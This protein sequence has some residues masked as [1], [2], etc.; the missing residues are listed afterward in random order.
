MDGYDRSHGRSL[1]LCSE[2]GGEG[3]EERIDGTVRHLLVR[4]RSNRCLYGDL[5]SAAW[6][7]SGKTYQQATDIAVLLA[8]GKRVLLYRHSPA[9]GKVMKKLVGEVLEKNGG[10]VKLLNNLEVRG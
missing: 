6:A 7:V 5:D 2:L 10:D 1:L 8:Q 9:A 3:D 4:A